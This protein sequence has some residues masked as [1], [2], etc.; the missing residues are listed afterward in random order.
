[1]YI[2]EVYKARALGVER[3]KNDREFRTFT[4]CVHHPRIMPE[5]GGTMCGARGENVAR[6]ADAA[7]NWWWKNTLARAHHPPYSLLYTCIYTF[8]HINIYINVFYMYGYTYI[9]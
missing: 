7:S 3:W 4:V 6:F 5:L 8:I 1:M 9:M 2:Y